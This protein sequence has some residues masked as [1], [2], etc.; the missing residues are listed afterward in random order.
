VR[1]SYGSSSTYTRKQKSTLCGSHGSPVSRQWWYRQEA[2]IA[3]QCNKAD[4]LQVECKRFAGVECD[5]QNL[6]AG[7]IGGVL[8]LLDL[9]SLRIQRIRTPHIYDAQPH[10]RTRWKAHAHHA[11][12]SAQPNRNILID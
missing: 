5:R 4:V 10:P 6:E 12:I 7:E 2:N 9:A 11:C 3:L 8:L 1:E